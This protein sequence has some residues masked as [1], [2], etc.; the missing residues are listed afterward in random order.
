[1]K[2]VLTCFALLLCNV[3]SHF[4]FAQCGTER[5]L[6]K[7]LQDAD[8]ANIRWRAVTS[9]VSGQLQKTKPVYHENN[10]RD[11]TELRVYKMDCILVKY[12][13]E[14]DHD[15]H[16]IVQDLVTN[17][18]MCVEIPDPADCSEVAANPRFSKIARARSRIEMN[19]GPVMGSY[20]T[21][22]AGKNKIQVTGVG[23]FDKK[24]H[25]TGFKGREL[26]PVL[27]LKFL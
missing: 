7:T 18:Q 19:V 21:P 16:L 13:E 8:T 11:S 5:W 9:T 22:P 6:V 14:D 23:F 4:L 2:T 3:Y 25:P 1:M 10:P 17:E 24:N 15:W 20:R 27:D 12:K 26:H